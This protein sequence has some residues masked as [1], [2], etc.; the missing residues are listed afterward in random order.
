MDKLRFKNA[1]LAILKAKPGMGSLQLR[2]ALLIADALHNT[3]HGKGI[4]GTRYIKHKFGPVP[5]ED[6]FFYLNQMSF[7]LHMVEIIEEP[8]GH[9][10]QNSYYNLVEP[11]YSVFTRGQIDILNYA[12]LTAWKY[13]ASR[14]SD[15]THDDVY[16]KTPMGEVIPLELVCKMTA[17]GYDTEPFTQQEKKEVERFFESSEACMFNFV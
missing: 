13:S 2:K 14:L 15:M 6:A 5:A 7:P 4:T 11:D 8:V 16:N 10:T 1:V 9:V 3:L 17:S 12:A